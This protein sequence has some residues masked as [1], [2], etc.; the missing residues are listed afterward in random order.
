[1]WIDKDILFVCFVVWVFEVI[2]NIK[3]SL[4]GEVSHEAWGI[5]QIVF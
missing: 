4:V 2:I 5:F 1:M 3:V